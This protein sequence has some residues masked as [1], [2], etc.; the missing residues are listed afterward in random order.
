MVWSGP[1][2]KIKLFPSNRVA[3]GLSLACVTLSLLR[4]PRENVVGLDKTMLE[5]I[6]MTW[7]M[8]FFMSRT[9]SG[10]MD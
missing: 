7:K 6:Q 9:L 4:I 8:A 5:M 1:E 10:E 2:L 3:N